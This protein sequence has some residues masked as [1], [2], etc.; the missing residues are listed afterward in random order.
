[1]PRE[2]RLGK[3]NAVQAKERVSERE[4][5]CPGR[6]MRDKSPLGGGR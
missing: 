1:M 5:C 2:Q 6:Q 4:G 3:G